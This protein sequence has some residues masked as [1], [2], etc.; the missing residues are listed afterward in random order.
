[1]SDYSMLMKSTVTVL[2]NYTITIPKALRKSLGGID[3]GDIVE[4]EITKISK[5]C[6]VEIE[7][8]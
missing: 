1:M 8:P 7:D 2:R 4:I 5:S 6:S 3:E